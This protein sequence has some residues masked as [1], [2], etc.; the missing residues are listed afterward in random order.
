[1]VPYCRLRKTCIDYAKGTKF[2]D[3]KA[4][5]DFDE[6]QKDG[7]SEILSYK[8]ENYEAAVDAIKKIPRKP[9][10]HM[11]PGSCPY[12][13]AFGGN[14]AKGSYDIPGYN[15]V[16]CQCHNYLKRVDEIFK[17]NCVGPICDQEKAAQT[18]FNA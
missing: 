16:V 17:E 13:S 2:V 12:S 10:F 14:H 4:H 15:C 6:I 7:L 3:L 11:K 1:M 18:E 5:P 9:T 8:V